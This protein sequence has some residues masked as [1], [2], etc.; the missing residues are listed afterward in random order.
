VQADQLGGDALDRRCAGGEMV[1][2]P[3][4][5]ASLRVADVDHSAI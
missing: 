4:P 5:G 2:A 3:E 1:P